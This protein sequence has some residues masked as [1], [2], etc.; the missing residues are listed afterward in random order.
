MKYI[1]AM[2]DNNEYS[3]D[4]ERQVDKQ[5]DERISRI[6]MAEYKAEAF[7]KNGR[8]KKKFQ[9]TPPTEVHELHDLRQKMYKSELT[10]EEVSATITCGSIQY[11]YLKS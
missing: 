8:L 4:L 7:S 11:K 3:S 10:P 1:A 9:L 5:I 6:M 2:N